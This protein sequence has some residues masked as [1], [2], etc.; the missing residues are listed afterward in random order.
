MA[1]PPAFIGLHPGRGAFPV[2]GSVVALALVVAALMP[3]RS[4]VDP[5]VPALALVLVPLVGAFGGRRLAVAC[6]VAGVL[7]FNFVF[8]RPFDSLAVASV[9]SV[10]A[11]IAYLT[12]SGVLGVAI[13]QLRRASAESRQRAVEAS[14]LRDLTIDLLREARRV[15]PAVT[16]SLERLVESLP[17]LGAAVDVHLANGERF[18]VT[19]GDADACVAAI[20]R[21]GSTLGERSATPRITDGSSDVLVIQLAAGD[22]RFGTLAV[23]EAPHARPTPSS[24]RVIGTFSNLITL[25]CERAQFV[26]ESVRRAALEQ[27]EQHRVTLVQSVSHDLRTPLTSMRALAATLPD[28]GAVT[29]AQRSVLDGIEHE[30]TRLATM[31]DQVLDLSRIDSGRL[32]PRFETVALDDIVRSAVDAVERAHPGVDVR[33]DIEPRARPVPVDEPL[34]RQV[35]VN[36]LENAIGHGAPP[37]EVSVRTVDEHTELRVR[38]HGAGIAPNDRQHMFDASWAMQRRTADDRARGLG[39]VIGAGFVRAHNGTLQVEHTPGGGATFVVSLPREP[40]A[41]R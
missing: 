12:V 38:D 33:V 32:M 16:G 19:A 23:R 34:I 6:S 1:R 3:I 27:S 7:A 14:L 25:A 30:A 10:T 2:V 26:D 22:A 8:T 24:V 13:D 17:L 39:L 5:A 15:R 21:D 41:A 40:S 29:P 20:E 4:D 36:L 31:V 18:T 11:F 37:F 9:T 35:V 28:L